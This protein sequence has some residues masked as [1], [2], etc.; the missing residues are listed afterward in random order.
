LAIE[1][2]VFTAEARRTQG[3]NKF[4]FL[5][6]GQKGKSLPLGNLSDAMCLLWSISRIVSNL[7]G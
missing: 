5:L 6:R 1:K 7:K 4:F 3:D 2:R